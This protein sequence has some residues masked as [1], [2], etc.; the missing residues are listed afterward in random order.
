MFSERALRFLLEEY[1]LQT[2]LFLPLCGN[3]LQAVNFRTVS[4]S[5]FLLT[6]LTFVITWVQFST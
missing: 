4:D 5:P 3:G 2:G 1:W 6:I